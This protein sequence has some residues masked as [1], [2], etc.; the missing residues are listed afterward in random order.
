MEKNLAW[1]VLLLALFTTFSS[2]AQQREL[3]GTVTDPDGMPLPGVAVSIENST[4]GTVTDFEGEFSLTVPDQDDVVLVFSYLGFETQR[5][6]VGTQTSF[7]I[8]LE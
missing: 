8:T 4:G 2:L 1:K 6:P 3:T 5:V 7:T